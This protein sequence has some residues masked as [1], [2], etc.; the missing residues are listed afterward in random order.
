M[1]LTY[2][3][4]SGPIGQVMHALEGDPRLDRVGFVGLGAGSLAY[5]SQPGQRWTFYEIDPSVIRIARDPRLFTFLRDARGT[6]DVVEG[7]GRLQLAASDATFGLLVL[8][9]FGSDAIPLHLLTR[10][11]MQIYRQR[12]QPHGIVALH[13]SNNYLDLEPVLANLARD[14]DPPWSCHVRND[15]FL[16]DEDREAG[17]FPSV[18]IV[19]AARDEDLPAALR[20]YPWRRASPR[21]DLPVWTDSWSNVWQVFRMAGTSER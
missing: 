8:D 21:D 13:V 14:A 16:T 18:W 12:M 2:Y 10:Q 15:Q 1:P 11:A 6:I 17:K 4:Q 7:D 5:Y 9:A 20:T 19:L 3:H